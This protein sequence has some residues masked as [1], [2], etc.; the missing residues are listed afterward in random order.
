[1]NLSDHTLDINIRKCNYSK[2]DFREIAEYVQELAGSREYQYEAI[3][4]VMIYLWG[5]GYKSVSDLARENFSKKAQIQHR[6]GT[7]EHFLYQFPLP[8]QQTGT[9]DRDVGAKRNNV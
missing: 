4:Q 9:A 1:M 6:F 8:N 5:R 7:E 3:K 2:F